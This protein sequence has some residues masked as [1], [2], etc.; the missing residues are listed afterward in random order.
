MANGSEQYSR[1]TG[2]HEESPGNYLDEDSTVRCTRLELIGSRVIAARSPP[3]SGFLARHL[4]FPL[5]STEVLGTRSDRFKGQVT[6][7]LLR[8]SE[9]ARV[10]CGNG[11]VT[12]RYAV[13]GLWE[14]RRRRSALLEAPFTFGNTVYVV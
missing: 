7:P 6:R 5:P 9:P 8:A 14:H 11:V 12:S 4:A 2:S 10:P 13:D 1:R 3:G